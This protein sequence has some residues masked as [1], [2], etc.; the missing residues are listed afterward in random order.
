VLG[1]AALSVALTGPGAVSLDTVIGFAPEG[2]AWGA[3]AA[4][5]AVVGALGQLA[6]R[7]APAA[8]EAAGHAP[9]AA[10]HRLH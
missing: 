2:F 3:A 5:L 7:H 4:I 10:G 1:V 8:S 6:Q 9:G